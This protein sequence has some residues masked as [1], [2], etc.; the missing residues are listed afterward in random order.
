[1]ELKPNDSHKSFYGKAGVSNQGDREYLRSY[2]TLVGYCDRTGFHRTWG[3]Y[4]ATTMRHVNAFLDRTGIK[5][6]GKSWWESLPVEQ[7]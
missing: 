3:G 4:S 6:G 1:M 2:K 7:N 5:G